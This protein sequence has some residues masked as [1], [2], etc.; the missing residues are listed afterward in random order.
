LRSYH[1]IM[2]VSAIVA[3]AKGNVIG[4]EQQIPW[5]LPA[6]LAWFKRT[7]L[8][9]HIIMGRKSFLSIGRPLPNRTN[10][11]VTRNPF[12]LADGC[13]V[14]HS[15]ENALEIAHDNGEQEAFIIGG[16]DIYKQSLALWDKLYI[17]EVDADVQGDTYLPA[18]Q[19]DEWTLV[20]EEAHLADEKNEFNYTFRVFERKNTAP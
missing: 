20:F 10:V 5:Y 12:F 1:L 6:D 16:G 8:N 13:L 15:I 17:T 19:P 9:H 18:I 3:V 7:T 11:V 2:I 14:A 4:F